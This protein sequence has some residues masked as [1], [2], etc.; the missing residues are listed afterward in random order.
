MSFTARNMISTCERVERTDSDGL[1]AHALLDVGIG[2]IIGVFPVQDSLIAKGI[3]ESGAT[4][5]A[6]Q[7][8]C[9]RSG[10]VARTTYRCP[11]RHRMRRS[12]VSSIGYGLFCAG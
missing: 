12:A 10:R 3:D 11:M 2:G 4:C 6:R 7:M 1:D 9:R 8:K 5:K